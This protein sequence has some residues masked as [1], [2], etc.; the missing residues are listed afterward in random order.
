MIVSERCRGGLDPAR[1]GYCSFTRAAS[2]A[3]RARVCE[4]LEIPENARLPGMGTIHSLCNRWL[5]VSPG[6]VVSPRAYKDFCS[7][8]GVRYVTKDEDETLVDD[9]PVFE[10]EVSHENEG[11]A[12][13]S[14]M[15]LMRSSLMSLEDAYVAFS[16][17]NASMW[18]SRS[19]VEAFVREYENWKRHEGLVDFEDM[20]DRAW[21]AKWVPDV[22]LMVLDEAQDLSASQRRLFG[23]WME[24]IPEVWIAFDEDQTI[25]SWHGADP[26]WLLG[27][28]GTKVYLEQSYRVPAEVHARAVRV[29]RLNERRFADKNWKP[30][31]GDPGVCDDAKMFEVVHMISKGEPPG[32]W[33]VLARNRYHLE[34]VV[35]ELI[36]EAVPFVNERGY[37]PLNEVPI[38]V[39]AAMKLA[40]G[41]RI[42]PFELAKLARSI[43]DQWWV[44]GA[45]GKIEELADSDADNLDLR[46]VAQIGATP[47]LMETFGRV[48]TCLEAV[49]G[50][51]RNA[52][53]EYYVRL[54]TERG[55]RALRDRPNTVLT[56]IHGA[57]G[58]EADNVALLNAVT[59][60]TFESYEAD[61]EP[62]RRVG[63]VGMTRSRN[64][65][66]VV[67]MINSAYRY[68]WL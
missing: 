68:G 55:F 6:A 48:E 49:E 25:Y 41:K 39:V 53:K 66:Y 47:R 58:R 44:A 19:E 15:G 67:N 10:G 60:R 59:R 23:L 61:P 51:L 14:F 2:Q 27:I 36:K 17:S 64:S 12:L 35:P 32:S 22:D 18:P 13:R 56:T 57:K 16:P 63:Y 5:G 21:K 65:L 45:K 9:T 29:I 26:A 28:Q 50:R 4:A 11:A 8:A 3:A 24:A 30:R 40:H 38:P 20:I 46:G 1:V 7:R 33:F 62:E 42:T 37:S 54:V 52:T 31:T 34:A 43:P